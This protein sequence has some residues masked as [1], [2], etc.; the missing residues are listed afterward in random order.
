MIA[1]KFFEQFPDIYDLSGDAIK[2][3]VSIG[4]LPPIKREYR[5]EFSKT[6]RLPFP[7]CYF[8]FSMY[9][10]DNPNQYLGCFIVFAFE[11]SNPN[12]IEFEAYEYDPLNTFRDCGLFYFDKLENSISLFSYNGKEEGDFAVAEIVLDDL[13]DTLIALECKNVIT[14]DNL[15]PNKLNKKRIQKNK[16]PLFTFKTLHIIQNYK[17]YKTLNSEEQKEEQRKSPRL[18]LR[19]GHIRHYENFQIW[20]EKTVVGDVKKGIGHKEYKI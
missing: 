14:I 1:H 20:I 18:H 3:E 2:F 4:S 5:R 17:R 19:R 11:N 12:E 7:K 16:I 8:E 9:D 15:P 13:L 6:A 10:D